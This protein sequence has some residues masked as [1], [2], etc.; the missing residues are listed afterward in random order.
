MKC[1]TLSIDVAKSVFQLHGVDER[2]HGVAQKR[3][4]RSRLLETIAQ[5]PPGM[6]GMEACGSAQYWGAGVAATGAYGQTDQPSV[7][8]AVWC[9]VKV[10]FVAVSLS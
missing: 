7:C 9:D 8:E 4:S 10:A 3:M 2:G 1:T 6:I 5:L